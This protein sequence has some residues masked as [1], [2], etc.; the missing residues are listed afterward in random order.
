MYPEEGAP[1]IHLASQLPINVA[2]QTLKADKSRFPYFNKVQILKDQGDGVCWTGATFHGIH[3]NK[4]LAL[5]TRVSMWWVISVQNMMR[6]EEYEQFEAGTDLWG[7]RKEA[8]F[9]RYEAGFHWTK[10]VQQY[11]QWLTY[12]PKYTYEDIHSMINFSEIIQWKTTVRS[13]KEQPEKK[14]DK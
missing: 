12:Q 7:N 4:S 5:Q 13:T 6:R 3:T 8:N 2:K 10:T 14:S 1:D 11:D 9:P